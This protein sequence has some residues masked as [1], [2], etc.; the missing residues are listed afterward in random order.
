[1]MPGSGTGRAVGL[2]IVLFA[3][4]K[5]PLLYLTTRR[6]LRAWRRWAQ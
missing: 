5:L 6:A 2:A 4:V 3:P 1:M